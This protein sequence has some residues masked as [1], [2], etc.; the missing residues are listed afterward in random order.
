MGDNNNEIV[1][2]QASLARETKRRNEV[3]QQLQGIIRD[4]SSRPGYKG[5]NKVKK[6]LKKSKTPYELVLLAQLTKEMREVVFSDTKSL[7]GTMDQFT[8]NTPGTLCHLIQ[9]ALTFPSS[10]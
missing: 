6:S 7:P 5:A 3:E 4:A 8:P 9:D 1:A 10:E 2:L